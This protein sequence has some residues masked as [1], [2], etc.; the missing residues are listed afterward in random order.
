[1]PNRPLSLIGAAR[2]YAAMNEQEMAKE[3]YQAYLAIRGDGSHPA[4]RE[5]RQQVG[6]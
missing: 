6:E 3:K 4:V 1:M 2:A 5:A